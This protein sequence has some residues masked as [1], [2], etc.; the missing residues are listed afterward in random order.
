MATWGGAN[1]QA[2]EKVFW[3]AGKVPQALK[4]VEK[5]ARIRSA[6]ALRDPKSASEGVFPQPVKPRP[7][8]TTYVSKKP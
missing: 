1:E 5:I 7:T 3:W 2:G 8:P 6:E 4:R